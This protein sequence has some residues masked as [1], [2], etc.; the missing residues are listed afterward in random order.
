MRQLIVEH[1]ADANGVVKGS[2]P[3]LSIPSGMRILQ[4]AMAFCAA[5]HRE[6]IRLLIEEG[7]AVLQVP[8]QGV[9]TLQ[10]PGRE[11]SAQ[12]NSNAGSEKQGAEN[13]LTTTGT[14]AGYKEQLVSPRGALKDIDH[15]AKKRKL[16]SPLGRGSTTFQHLRM[17]HTSKTSLSRKIDYGPPYETL[18]TLILMA[19]F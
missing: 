12:S 16:S 9:S 18:K 10:L 7:G 11:T 14:Y 13:K 17:L 5:S 2:C 4:L 8:A 15:A 6:V 1:G 19:F 3:E